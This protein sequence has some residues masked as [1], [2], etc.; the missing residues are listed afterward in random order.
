MVQLTDPVNA[1]FAISMC[2]A[3][4]AP[5]APAPDRMLITPGGKPASLTSSPYAASANGDFSDDLMTKVLPAAN[6]GAIFQAGQVSMWQYLMNE[7][8]YLPGC[9]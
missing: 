1:I 4:M 2:D 7:D 9:A 6:A 8:N 3:N 5:T